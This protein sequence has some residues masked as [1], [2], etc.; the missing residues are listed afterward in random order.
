MNPLKANTN[1][2][3][4]EDQTRSQDLRAQ[5]QP[6]VDKSTLPLST[7]DHP[8]IKPSPRNHQLMAESPDL[9]ATAFEDN[10]GKDKKTSPSREKILDGRLLF[11]LKI[12]DLTTTDNPFVFYE[13]QQ[14]DDEGYLLFQTESFNSARLSGSLNR[15]KPLPK[16]SLFKSYNNLYQYGGEKNQ[17]AGIDTDNEEVLIGAIG[18]LNDQ[19][20]CKNS[21]NATV[22]LPWL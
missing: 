3:D 17:F 8:S 20:N 22:M 21:L 9:S 10:N 16:A 11:N 5:T 6:D 4:P 7:N 13:N 19:S 15:K 1:Y 12:T 14:V 2:N 18:D